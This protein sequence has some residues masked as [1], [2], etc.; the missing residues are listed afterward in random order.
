MFQGQEFNCTYGSGNTKSIMYVYKG[1]YAL[2][3]STNVN[4]TNDD[5]CEGVNVET[6]NDYDYFT[7]S[8]PIESLDNLISEVDESEQ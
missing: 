1:W 8:N 3:G 6:L 7:A 5:I 2:D 4:R